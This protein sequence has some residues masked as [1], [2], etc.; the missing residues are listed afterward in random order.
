MRKTFRVGITPAALGPSTQSADS[1]ASP[2]HD[3]RVAGLDGLRAT[4]AEW[5][6]LPEREPV[7]GLDGL[8]AVILERATLNET[9][10]EK[11]DELILVARY[12]VGYDSV[13]LAACTR[14]RVI[15]TNA[16]DGSRRAMAVANLALILALTLR[17][18]T[19][20]RLVRENRWAEWPLHNGMGLAGRT[21]GVVGFGSIGRETLRLAA[22]ME[23][24][25]LVYDHHA[26]EAD[27]RAVGGVA[28]PLQRLLKEA[29]V[30][31]LAVPLTASTFHM[32]GEDELRLMKSTAYLVNTAR[33]AVIEQQALTRALQE[34]WIAGAG[35]D[36]LEQEPPPEG[37]PLLTLENVILAPH[38]LGCTD[39]S[40][41]L[42]GQSVV[43]SIA[44]VMN[45]RVPKF[46]VNPQVLEDGDFRARL[47]S[48]RHA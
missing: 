4:G 43:A 47:E 30:V 35:L 3:L 48:L 19:K 29:D 23:M 10:L 38:A 15:V 24:R 12:G 42:T 14:R 5:S 34:R 41:T 7:V 33:G 1:S 21:L 31:C 32:I 36:V 13:D 22:P 44:D 27:V 40:F 9:S 16:P 26:N 6:I 46:V 18:T 45:G 37:D 20:D 28:V 17:M 25:H 39:E 11:A 2:F 8:H